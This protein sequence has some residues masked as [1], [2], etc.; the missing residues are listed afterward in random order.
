[1][2]GSVGAYGISKLLESIFLSRRDLGTIHAICLVKKIASF[3][4]PLQHNQTNQKLLL[5]SL[6]LS[7]SSTLAY[8]IFYQGISSH[9]NLPFASFFLPT[10]MITKPFFFMLFSPFFL[11]AASNP[12]ME[13]PLSHELQDDYRI[14]INKNIVG[15]IFTKSL[16]AFSNIHRMNHIAF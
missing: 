12:P 8:V 5:Y 15:D 3:Y 16:I 2:K 11:S 14:T 13:I 10:L 7:L 1:M 6:S 4:L 9:E